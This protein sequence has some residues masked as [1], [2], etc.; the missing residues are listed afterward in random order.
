MVG[1]WVECWWHIVSRI[2][3]VDCYLLSWPCTYRYL[4]PLSK[5]AFEVW[6]S[7]YDSTTSWAYCVSSTIEP[8]LLTELPLEVGR[9]CTLCDQWRVP[10]SRWDYATTSTTTRWPSRASRASSSSGSCR[11][12]RHCGSKVVELCLE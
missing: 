3:P 1:L 9:P 11:Y 5:R 6:Y 12:T 2:C 7:P 10:S 4:I 8:D